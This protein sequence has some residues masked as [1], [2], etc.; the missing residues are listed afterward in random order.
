MKSYYILSLLFILILSSCRDS[1]TNPPANNV[2]SYKKVTIIDSAGTR[3]ELW[4]LG[5][6]LLYAGYNEIGFKVF[7]N[8]A[9]QKTGFVKFTPTMHH[10]GGSTHTTPVSNIFNY[11][12]Q[13]SMYTGYACFLMAS[14]SSTSFWFGDFNYND[15]MIIKLR[16][17]TVNFIPDFKMRFFVDT[18]TMLLYSLTLISPENPVIGS[19]EFKCIMHRQDNRNVYWEVDSAEM[20]LRTWANN[21]FDFNINIQNPVWIGGGRY[22]GIVDIPGTGKWVTNDSIKYQDH[23]ITENPPPQFYFKIK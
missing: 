14:D 3:F 15:E 6:S 20:S 22:Q 18:S 13:K 4:N 21:K 10:Q 2:V 19:N 1:V 5:D 8:A 9:E 12:E 7:V 11:D 17:F 23:I 16:L